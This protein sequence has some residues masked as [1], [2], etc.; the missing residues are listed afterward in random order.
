M[1][2]DN[3]RSVAEFAVYDNLLAYDDS[4]WKLCSVQAPWLSKLDTRAEQ[5]VFCQL[6]EDTKSLN[7][8]HNVPKSIGK[9]REMLKTDLADEEY[10]RYEYAL[11]SP[12][13]IPYLTVHQLEEHMKMVHADP[14]T[15]SRGIV[16]KGSRRL[17]SRYGLRKKTSSAYSGVS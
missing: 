10:V 9:G 1:E 7:D 6:C 5:G 2:P 17:D 13:E 14:E 11:P 15:K 12:I 16:R 3:P 4:Y 8:G